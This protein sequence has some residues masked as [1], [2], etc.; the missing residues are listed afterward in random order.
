MAS[1]AR[2]LGFNLYRSRGSSRLKLNRRLIAGVASGAGRGRAY[3]FRDRVPARKARYWL[4]V[5]DLDG[6]RVL[7][8]PVAPRYE[9]Q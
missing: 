7:H 6:K 8:G 1:S 2:T 4:Q 3:L 9:A 5:V